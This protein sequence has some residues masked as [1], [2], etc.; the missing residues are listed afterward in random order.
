MRCP[1]GGQVAC[2]VATMCAL[3]ARGAAPHSERKRQGRSGHHRGTETR[4]AEKNPPSEPK[5]WSSKHCPVTRKVPGQ[6]RFLRLLRASLSSRNSSVP[7]PWLLLRSAGSLSTGIAQP[8]T[9]TSVFCPFISEGSA[10]EWG[11]GRARGSLENSRRVCR[12]LPTKPGSC[13]REKLAQYLVHRR[14]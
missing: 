9:R 5:T 11:A 4:E 8:A 12:Q 7:L 3:K 1:P 10:L 6:G 13:H 14:P 2:P